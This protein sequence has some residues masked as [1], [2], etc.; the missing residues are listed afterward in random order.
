MKR[1]NHSHPGRSIPRLP[2]QSGF[3]LIELMIVVAVM[4]ILASIAYPSYLEYVRRTNRAEARGVLTE[5]SQFLERNYTEANRY[6][7][8]SGG[9]A[10]VLPF[11]T[12]PKT[13][14][15]RYNITAAYGAAPAQTFTLSAAPTGSMAGDACGTLTLTN[16]GLQGVAGGSLSVATCWQK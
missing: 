8:D 10:V 1:P 9:A 6:D 15:A 2:G 16:T 5:N 7:L 3:T 12:S 14:P 13:P 4:A 11:T